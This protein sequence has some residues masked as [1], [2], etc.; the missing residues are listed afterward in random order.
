MA[1]HAVAEREE[2]RDGIDVGVGGCGAGVEYQDGGDGAVCAEG[3]GK[4]RVF[5]CG[6]LGGA[7]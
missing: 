6:R 5:R 7:R 1:V 4:Q 2:R 3:P